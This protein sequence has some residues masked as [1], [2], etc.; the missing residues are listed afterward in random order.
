VGSDVTGIRLG[1]I[2]SAATGG[3]YSPGAIVGDVLG[4]GVWSGDLANAGVPIPDVDIPILG[5]VTDFG[6]KLLFEATGVGLN[7]SNVLIDPYKTASAINAFASG[8]TPEQ[9]L[10]QYGVDAFIQ[11]FGDLAPPE[12][13]A[14]LENLGYLARDVMYRY[15]PDEK[16]LDYALTN[17]QMINA[18]RDIAFLFGDP[19]VVP[20]VDRVA[21]VAHMADYTEINT[22]RKLVTWAQYYALGATAVEAGADSAEDLGV[23]WKFPFNFPSEPITDGPSTGGYPNFLDDKTQNWYNRTGTTA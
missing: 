1:S 22:D 6:G 13:Q 15:S 7:G 23:Q 18:G 12:A 3:Y 4:G 2:V 11:T 9:Y 8:T 19:S 16:I 10:A 5:E 14:A 20:I 17:S 21:N